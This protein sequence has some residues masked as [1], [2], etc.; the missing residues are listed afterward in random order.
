MKLYIR[1]ESGKYRVASEYA[2]L[3]EARSISASRLERHGNIAS[4]EDATEYLKGVY[5]GLPY[6][7]FGVTFLD[8]KHRIIC[9]EQM[10]RGTIDG[11]SVHP[12][13]VVT[14][15]ILNKAAA[16]L[17]SHNHPSGSPDP[18]EADR[19]LTSRLKDALALISVRTLDHIIVAGETTYSF[20]SRGLL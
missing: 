10:F 18:S 19:L 9:H 11:A 4:P 8:N 16:V 20:A 13:E 14:A 1:D 12:R 2:V 3:Y 17:L 6:E 5:V 15:V 7:V